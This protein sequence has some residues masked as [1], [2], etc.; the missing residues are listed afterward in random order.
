MRSSSELDLSPARQARRVLLLSLM[1]FVPAFSGIAFAQ[2]SGE[3][4]PAQAKARPTAKST[5]AERSA[6]RAG[7][8]TEGGKAARGPQMGEVEVPPTTAPR[9]SK[10][11]RNAATAQ[12]RAAAREAN[13]RGEFTRG[14]NTDAPETR[15]P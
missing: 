3:A 1:A 5:P 13:R 15:K 10:A 14:G 8:A 4:D 6:A 9:L 2:G 12:R 7:R 11:E